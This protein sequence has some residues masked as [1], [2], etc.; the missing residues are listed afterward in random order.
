MK[1]ILLITLPIFIF[2]GILFISEIQRENDPSRQKFSVGPDG[3]FYATGTN[4]LYSGM[5][6]DTADVIIE[7]QVVN[8]I[9]NGSFK[10]YFLTGQLEKEGYIENDK[11]EGEWKYYYEN[12]HL[13]VIGNFKENLANDQWISYY[14]NGNIKISGNYKNGKQFGAWK[15]YDS[16][17]ELINI[18]YY[19][20]GKI[21]DVDSLS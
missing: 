9:K 12:G 3:L 21:S 4:E 7:F 15:Y 10:T 17:G 5:I 16:N 18:I 13:E 19:I 20:D 1:K 14:N 2:L 11:N 6:I 8:G